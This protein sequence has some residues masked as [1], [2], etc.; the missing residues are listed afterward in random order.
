MLV[1]AAVASGLLGALTIGVFLLPLA[2]LA[3]I[4]LRRLPASGLGVAGVVAG[5]GLGP[6]FVAYLNRDGPG[7][8]CTATARS[9]ACEQQWS[10]WPWL[11][12]GVI[13]LV[14]GVALFVGR[15]GWP[16]A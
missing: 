1:G 5:A 16:P 12:A 4:G 7:D 8:V 9:L 10:P 13:L 11:A 15:A 2:A 14:V 6:L 3:T